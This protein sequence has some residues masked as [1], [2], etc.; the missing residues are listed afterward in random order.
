MKRLERCICLPRMNISHISLKLLNAQLKKCRQ[1]VSTLAHVVFSVQTGNGIY[2]F[3]SHDITEIA[4]GNTA[5]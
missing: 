4:N 1:K 5:V 3:R 2:A